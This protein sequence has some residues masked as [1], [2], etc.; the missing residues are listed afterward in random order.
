MGTY[1]ALEIRKT[2]TSYWMV[3]VI[4]QVDASSRDR[5]H[6]LE[7]RQLLL[8]AL[9]ARVSPLWLGPGTDGVR[10]SA[11]FVRDS[12]VMRCDACQ[13][14]GYAKQGIGHQPLAVLPCRECGGTGIISCCDGA[15]GE[16]EPDDDDDPA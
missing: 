6:E 4:P 15:C 14:T 16:E 2:A 13:G 1:N 5:R 10:A 9:R 12:T 8:R 3:W 11:T 7:G